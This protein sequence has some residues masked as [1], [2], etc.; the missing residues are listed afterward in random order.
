MSR[1]PRPAGCGT[2]GSR[3][4]RAAGRRG[5]WRR[6]SPPGPATGRRG[7]RG[8]RRRRTPRRSDL[9][10]RRREQFF[11]FDHGPRTVEFCR[12][13]SPPA[14]AI[15][16]GAFTGRRHP[17][18]PQRGGVR[19]GGRLSLGEA[20]PCPCHGW[21][22]LAGPSSSSLRLRRGTEVRPTATDLRCGGVFRRQG[23]Q[24][25]G[26]PVLRPTKAEHLSMTATFAGLGLHADLVAALARQ[27]SPSPSHPGAHHRRRS[28]RARR[29]GQ[30]QDRLGQDPGLRTPLLGRIGKA[31]PRRP[32]GPDPRPHP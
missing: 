21:E 11:V 24:C 8:R 2:P 28:R 10:D 16:Q 20:A 32:Q 26:H 29:A 17:L 14:A 18:V 22:A 5:R 9:G 12:S 31:E 7:R 23:S 15:A 4:C 27:G 13:G 30:G 3:A 19:I 6:R 1:R 25:G